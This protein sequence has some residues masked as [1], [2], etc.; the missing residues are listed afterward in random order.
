[1]GFGEQAA[2]VWVESERMSE[3]EQRE[4]DSLLFGS[5]A[6]EIQTLSDRICKHWRLLNGVMIKNSGLTNLELC[7]EGEKKQP[8]TASAGF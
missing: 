8:L 5:L 1:M 4:Q 6:N 2:Q 3:E 7:C